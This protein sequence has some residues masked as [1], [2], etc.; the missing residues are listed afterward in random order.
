MTGES[1]TPPIPA[2]E[3]A[4][5]SSPAA[6]NRYAPF[7]TVWAILTVALTL[8][9]IVF[10]SLVTSHTRYQGDQIKAVG[11]SI[12]TWPWGSTWNI[13]MIHRVTAMTVGTCALVLAITLAA[14]EPRRWVRWLGYAAL[15][16][17][18]LEALLGGL[19][20]VMYSPVH[21]A[22]NSLGRIG[23]GMIHATFA[24]LI[25]AL[26]VIVALVTTKGWLEAPAPV[27]S[28]DTARTRRLA[29]LTCAMVAI[30][31]LIGAWARH[32]RML[33]PGGTVN[34]VATSTGTAAVVSNHLDWRNVAVWIHVA[35]A[36]SV[37]VHVV[38]LAVRT[39]SKH[40]AVFQIRQTAG[41]VVFFVGLQIVLGLFAWVM[42]PTG[43]SATQPPAALAD[44]VRSG[45]VA[46]G[47][48]I[49]AMCVVVAA[50]SFLLLQTPAEAARRVADPRAA[51]Q[52]ETAQNELHSQPGW[53]GANPSN[54]VPPNRQREA[55]T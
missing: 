31:I 11:D 40:P 54:V 18:C 51:P 29:I 46:N 19:R 10:G 33:V 23:V 48:M 34:L 3:T 25:F 14:T 9:L 8:L 16:C 41:L 22:Y 15:T 20:V 49:L 30:Q 1:E 43:L 47:A 7:L 6:R 32:L 12:S 45:H 37:A 24:Q 4:P 27:V 35:M 36:V 39:S 13:E 44:I 26:T 38:L 28:A 17:V 2:P 5:A 21:A 52:A 42:T 55:H 50:R 53:D